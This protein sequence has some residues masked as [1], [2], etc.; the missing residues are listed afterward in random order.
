[1]FDPPF[2]APPVLVAL[3]IV[4]ASTLGVAT[5]LAP[6]PPSDASS[7]AAAVDRAAA[8]QTPTT[9]RHPTGVDA[10]KIEPARIRTRDD[11]GEHAAVFA[12]GRVTPVRPASRLA[13]VLAGDPPAAVFRTPVDLEIA[14]R[15]AR[16]SPPGWQHDPARIR[17]RHV[18][19]GEVDVTLVGV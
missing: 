19:W 9:D 8:S 15:Y 7:L 3:T 4:A 11:T 6:T 1:M 14:A 17:V 12:T 2:D 5:V 18:T 16:E 10:V 13:S